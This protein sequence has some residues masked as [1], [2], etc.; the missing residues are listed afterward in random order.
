[1]SKGLA[2]TFSGQDIRVRAEYNQSRVDNLQRLATHWTHNFG[3][4]IILEHLGGNNRGNRSRQLWHDALGKSYE[5]PTIDP[6]WAMSKIRISVGSFRI[7]TA[8]GPAH[9]LVGLSKATTSNV[10]CIKT[11]V[12]KFVDTGGHDCSDTTVALKR[13]AQI[14]AFWAT[15]PGPKMMWQFQEL[16]YDYPIEF[17]CR[18]CPKP[19]RW[20]Y[21]QDTR[22]Q[23]LY[24]KFARSST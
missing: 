6:R 22:R 4:Y 1:M 18:T 21:L 17:G 16:G 12:W 7:N 5:N 19:I 20:N 15:V 11:S 14:A 9:N 13:M 10:R 2:N 24:K 3:K 23:L 8:A